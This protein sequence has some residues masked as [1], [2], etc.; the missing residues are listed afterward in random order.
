[1]LELD[2]KAIFQLD[3]M[4]WAASSIAVLTHTSPDG[5]A[6]GSTVAVASFL[7]EL[8]PSCEISIIYDTLVPETLSFLLQEVSQD[9]DLSAR[10]RLKIA[11]ALSEPLRA[12]ALLDSA[13]LVFC[14]DISGLS[15]CGSLC[16]AASSSKAPRVL[17]DHHLNPC[18]EEF[19]LMFSRT[20][21]SSSCELLY[22][23]LKAMPGVG[24]DVQRI[25]S[26]ARRALMTGM[27]T[28]TNNFANSVFPSTLTMASELIASGVDRDDI[29]CHL[30][31]SYRENRVRA[32][33]HLLGER[34]VVRPEGYAY[35]IMNYAEWKN[36]G[37]RDGELEGLVNVPLSIRE[38]RL[39]L[40]LREDE[41]PAEGE[42]TG[43]KFRVSIRSKRGVSAN[44]LAGS[45]FH[46]GGHEQAS[47]GKLFYPADIAG[48]TDAALYV[49]ESVR[50]FLLSGTENAK[51]DE[52]K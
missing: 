48:P 4:L 42:Q 40:F 26:V 51:D 38:V 45:F 36:F 35:I 47:G 10:N 23:I 30:L 12:R 3:S 32:F 15:R 11:V 31:Q 5:D 1:M 27:T 20:D 39:S 52:L 50:K 7:E 2:S 49:D 14:T 24:G 44:R 43:G 37:L 18:A 34:M 17:G 16:D 25:P 19:S 8:Y 9:D 6:I 41:P 22:W 21:I 29:L 13:D 46:G 33:A 28:D